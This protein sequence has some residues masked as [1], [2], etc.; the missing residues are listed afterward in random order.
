MNA[1]LED[2]LAEVIKTGDAAAAEIE[3]AP[4]TAEGQKFV[5]E[6]RA[7]REQ[8][9]APLAASRGRVARMAARAG[10]P[11]LLP[12]RTSMNAARLVST[13]QSRAAVPGTPLSTREALAEVVSDTLRSIRSD[14]AGRDVYC[15]RATWEYPDDR[16]LGTDPEENTRKIGDVC[17]LPAIAASGGSCLPVNVDYSVPTWATP[18]RPLRDALPAFQADRGGLRFVTPPDITGL[19]GATSIW[20]EATDAAPGGA[21]KPVIVV[22]C[23]TEQLVYVDAVP[24]RLQFGNMESR[25][26][27][28]QIAANTDLAMSSAA[29]I[30]EGNL[31]NKIIAASTAVSAAQ[32]LGATRDLLAS[33]DLVAAGYRYRHRIPR[34]VGLTFVAPDWVHDLLRADIAREQAHDSNGRD[35]LAVTNAQIDS[36]LT[37]RQITPIWTLDGIAGATREGVTYPNQSL[38][39]QAAGAVNVWP[40]KLS[41]SLFVEGTFQFLDG[42]RLDL[43]VVRDST[44]D[45]TNDYE[46]FVETFEGVADR[47]VEALQVV[48]TIVPN[49]A[50]GALVSESGYAE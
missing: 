14:R 12:G 10:R 3:S 20:T 19:A 48:S 40:T 25:F 28:E 22:A 13:T 1:T 8:F 47:G 15:A 16:T 24:T 9:V 5:A 29:R 50:S 27:P 36:W 44:L 37:A 46:T 18:A 45:A 11:T 33:I 7:Q 31:L 39:T 34:S 38:G 26:A 41:W 49:G 32:Y 4:P 21:T 17:G 42:G 23:G 2:R 6:W 30:A 43:G 35:P